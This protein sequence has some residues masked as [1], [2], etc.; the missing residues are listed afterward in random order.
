MNQPVSTQQPPAHPD[1]LF[2]PAQGEL[3]REEILADLLQ[4]SAARHPDHPALLCGQR[5]LSYAELDAQATVVAARLIADGV[6]PGQIVGLWLP[7]GIE[8]LVLQAGIAKAGAAWLPV[9]EDTPVERL[10]VCLDDAS[11]AGVLTCAAFAPRLAQLGRPVWTAEALLAGQPDAA[12][13]HASAAAAELVRA[14]RADVTPDMPAYV[15]Y[16]SGSTGKPKGIL[17]NQ[18]SICHFL[19][20]ENA[21]LGVH[22]DDKVYQGFSV[23]FDMSFEEIW[24]AYLVG[25]TLWLGPKEISGDPETLPRMLA[26]QQVTVLHAVPTL[27]AL[28]NQEVPSLRLI[29]LG[30]EMCPEALVERWSRPGRQMFNTY[31]PTEATVSASLARLQPGQPVT[32]GTPLPNYGLLVIDAEAAASEPPQLKLLARG[33][34]GELCITGPGLAAGYLGRPD[35]TAEKFLSNPWS[36]GQHDARLYRTGDLARIGADGE[37]VC[38]GR[39]DDQV[40]IRGFRVELGEIEA[41]L[42]QQPGVGTVAVLLRKDDGIDQLVA[43]LVADAGTGAGISAGTGTVP[44]AG[45]GASAGAPAPRMLRAALTASLPP[46]MVP[47]RYQFLDAMPRLTSGKIDRKALKALPLQP[48]SAGAGA[49]TCSDAG[50]DSDL[51]ETPAEQALFAALA[52]LFPGQPILRQADFFSDLGGHSFFAARL[53][54]ALRAD[55]RFAH[56]TV[57]DIYQQRQIGKIA[58]VLA[59]APAAAAAQEE[60][61]W[62]PP[63]TLKRWTCGLAQAAAMPAL[64]A[65]RMAQWLAP[66]FTYHFFTGDPGDSVA[67][68]IAAS[69]AVF[70]LATLAEFAIAIAGKWLIAGR[71]Q[72]GSYPL[73]GWTYYRWW[74]ADRLVEAAP[75]YLLSG[76]SLS[77]WWLRALGAK[78]GKEVIIGSM[79]LRAPDLLE[80]GDNVSVG[81][82]V[83]F[84]NARVQRGRLLLGR[85]TLEQDACVSSFAVLE[86]NTRVEALGHLEGQSALADG[87]TVTAGRVWAGSPARDVG[88]F[89]SSLLP[90][91]PHASALR[92]TGEALFFLFGILLIVTLFFMPVFPSFVLIDWFDEAGWLPWIQGDDLRIQLLRY[93]LLAFPASTVLI[94][95]TALLSAGIRWSVLPRLRPG[96]FAIHSRTYCAKWLVSQIQ[97]SSLNVLHGIYATVF[98]PNWYRLLGAKVGKDAEISTAL[99]VVPDMLT[100]GD[101]TFIADAVMLGDEEIDGG[102]MTMQPTVVSH[103]SFVGNGAYI[104]DGTVLPEHVL[105]GVHSRAPDNS[106]MQSGD[107]WLGSPPINLPAREQT[108]GYPEW[109]TFH[110]SPLRRL[111]RGLI[112]AFR[113]VAPHALVIAVGY[114]LVLAVMPAAGAGRWAEVTW[115]LTLAGLAYGMGNYVFVVLLKWLLIGRYR[116]QSEPMWTPFVWLS[117]GVTNLYEG[118]AVPNFMRYLR[119]TPW[120]PLA[121]NLL[122]CRI[123]KGVYLDTTDITE[124]D[125]VHIGDHSELNALTCPQTHL[126]EDRV[127]KIDHVQI[128]SKV[129][130]GPRSAVLYSAVVGDQA[131]LGALTLVMKGEQIPP[132]SYWAGCPAAPAR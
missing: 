86:G 2:G 115:D 25:A 69:V 71:L 72:A 32:I 18:R 121:F 44:E 81:N 14:R 83:N 78:I 64:V 41:V 1:I 122:G 59:D 33:A 103:R 46:Y 84:E 119:G 105:I 127:M 112:E 36:C 114:T 63:S 28:F 126:F 19:R 5:S 132:R 76:S 8:L 131:R 57:R 48:D 106:R 88:P 74:L 56:I 3:L 23:A 13:P 68:A 45:T 61:P 96:R 35:L 20:S 27:L 47:G 12:P 107:T 117:E 77:S 21:V 40:K 120:L 15:I 17:I 24:I 89:D 70:L 54:S 66:F 16:T 91:R 113:I 82:A 100:L 123:G 39:A 31:G 73:W 108:S 75:A 10:Q 53:A 80:I 6:A 129:Y 9:D 116:K 22:A 85:I 92:R 30:G 102:W 42:A 93:F 124:F 37:V 90:P 55:P 65:L 67:R 111:G 29:N 4:A 62:S 130:M 58:Q 98:A 79:T 104:P 109:L 110:P 34:T 49:G 11:G 52:T 125:C 101:E 128:G 87:Q 95:L 50:A 7:R 99:G 26:E 60:A 51:A 118:I 43:Y 97:E 94:I 38:L